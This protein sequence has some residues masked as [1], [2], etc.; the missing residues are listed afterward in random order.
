[1]TLPPDRLLCSADE[2]QA[3]PATQACAD[4][5]VWLRDDLWYKQASVK[6][7]HYMP[8]GK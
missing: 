7:P 5:G 1:M 4:A 8:I 6:A 3:W 2:P